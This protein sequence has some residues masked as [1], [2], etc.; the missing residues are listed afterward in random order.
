MLLVFYGD[1]SGDV[2]AA[3]AR[4]GKAQWHF[5]TNGSPITYT[6]MESSLLGSRS[7]RIFSALLCL[8]G[9]ETYEQTFLETRISTRH[10]PTTQPDQMRPGAGNFAVA[11]EKA[12][13]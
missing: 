8:E 13:A 7:A 3:D 9:T 1:P 2:V 6:V 12:A 4:D 10:F 11:W 5:P